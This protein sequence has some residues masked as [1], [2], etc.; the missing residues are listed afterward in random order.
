MLQAGAAAPEICLNSLEGRPFRL[1]EELR[2]SPVLLVFYKIS[3][4]T[5][6]F[7]LPFLERLYQGQSEATPR[8]FGV[9]QDK[10][11]AT[12]EF[13]QQFGIHFPVL[14]DPAAQGYIASNAYRI[15]NV[16]SLFLIDPAGRIEWELNGFHK[17]EL[18]VL[19][20]R[21]GHSPF[22]PGERVPAMRPG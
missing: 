10:T 7:T 12:V 13:N 20:S 16:P 2:K 21:F 8:V 19:G 22:T 3:C 4:P 15:T 5:C 14:L 1:E 11:P 18:E 9:S 17:Q 6:Q